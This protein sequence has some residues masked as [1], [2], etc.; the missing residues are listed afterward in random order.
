[1]RRARD[2]EHLRLLDGLVDRLRAP[3][4]LAGR[5][6]ERDQTAVERADDELVFLER[7]AARVRVAAG[8]GA[9][10]TGHLGIVTPDE[11]ARCGVERVRLAPRRCRIEHTVGDER[12]RFLSTISVELVVPGRREPLDV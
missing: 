5:A 7:G 11:L 4:R 8:F 10:G 1:A 12:R 6:V 3:N 9:F 2:R